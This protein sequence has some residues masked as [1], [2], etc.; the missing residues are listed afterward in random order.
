M[1]A[2]LDNQFVFECGFDLAAVVP[3]HDLREIA[4][5]TEFVAFDVGPEAAP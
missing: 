5:R 2:N 4:K 1:A 3:K